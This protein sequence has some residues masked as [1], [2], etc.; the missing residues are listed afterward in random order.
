MWSVMVYGKPTQI[1]SSWVVGHCINYGFV[2]L[3]VL[4]MVY[5]KPTQIKSSWVVGHCIN[6]GF[7]VLKVLV[8]MQTIILPLP[9]KSLEGQAIDARSGID[10][11]SEVVPC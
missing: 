11:W 8:A 6:Y 7:V 3:K 9:W 4:V 2:V 5:G 1:K 10:L